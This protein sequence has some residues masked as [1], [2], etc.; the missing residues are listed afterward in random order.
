VTG[1]TA[2]RL[3]VSYAAALK[4]QGKEFSS[5]ASQAKLFSTE[6]ALRVCDNAIQIHGGYGYTDA[7][8]V[9]RHW[10]DARGLTI[11][12]G[13]SDMLRLLIAHLA[14]KETR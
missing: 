3:L 8:D 13:T 10:R 6:M 14:L 2:A 12:E 1:I 9:H 7:Y 11:G 5:E 4:E